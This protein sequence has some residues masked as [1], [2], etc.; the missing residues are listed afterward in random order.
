MKIK[1]VSPYRITHHRT[2]TQ[3]YSLLRFFKS[4]EI[5]CCE[6]SSC[7]RFQSICGDSLP[8]EYWKRPS[9]KE[10]PTVTI[11]L[12]C[13]GQKLGYGRS[14]VAFMATDPSGKPSQMRF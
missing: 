8:T 4:A 5:S 3:L 9:S 7:C 12:K 6:L 11:C 10:T 13:D 14:S 1:T 2:A